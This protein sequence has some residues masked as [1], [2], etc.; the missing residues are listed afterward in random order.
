MTNEDDLDAEGSSPM[1]VAAQQAPPEPPRG[2]GRPRRGASM[3][4][5]AGTAT[6]DPPAQQG[7]P[8]VTVRV[9][10]QPQPQAPKPE[11]PAYAEEPPEDLTTMELLAGS[12]GGVEVTRI[13]PGIGPGWKG[14]KYRGHVVQMGRAGTLANSPRLLDD[15][16]S[17]WGGSR[18][19]FLGS[20]NGKVVE[21]EKILPGAPKD[22]IHED[23]DDDDDDDLPPSAYDPTNLFMPGLGGLGGQGQQGQDP[24]WLWS[25][26]QSRYIYMGRGAPQ[27]PPPPPPGQGAGSF[28]PRL[29]MHPSK[30]AESELAELR[31]KV[32]IE[33]L[34]NELQAL[35]DLIRQQYQNPVA[36]TR[37]PFESIAKMME[38]Q[39][40]QAE[41]D[42]KTRAD[43]ERVR[44]ER[45][46]IE[47][48]TRQDRLDRER[49]EERE[50]YDREHKESREREERIQKEARDREDRRIAEEARRRDEDRK[51]AA[52][53]RTE[54]ARRQ[55]AMLKAMTEKSG[56]GKQITEM[57]AAMGALKSLTEKPEAEKGEYDDAKDLIRTGAEALAEHIIPA[58][59]D[60]LAQWRASKQPVMPVAPPQP[61]RIVRATAMPQQGALPAP[62]VPAQPVVSQRPRSAH[63]EMPLPF[64]PTAAQPQLTPDIIVQAQPTQ[65]QTVEPAQ[66]P[67]P[68]QSQQA[69]IENRIWVS[70]MNVMAE[71]NREGIP[72]AEAVGVFQKWCLE[73]GIPFE[74]VALRLTETDA[75]SVLK[76]L[77]PYVGNPL[78][79]ASFQATIKAAVDM[80]STEAG[81]TWFD[82]VADALEGSKLNLPSM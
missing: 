7:A 39:A 19:K 31:R 37:D 64:R 25:P 33:P 67:T 72:P 75:D 77:S 26:A 41:I 28:D 5:G 30:E 23:E 15:A 2:R 6:V 24:G 20:V 10:P 52:A 71:M 55:D 18:Y 12:K 46:R 8:T 40:K 69:E 62:V 56:I 35:K 49:K 13:G 16:Q 32:E 4:N 60:A 1:D 51:D 43:E 44:L 45:E 27:S 76:E 48:Q 70:V 38:Q 14:S 58:A 11:A 80:L 22:L 3:V 81:S 59:S 50:K 9:T 29:L 36:P 65:A 82:D 17:Q 34:K 21:F 53:A 74:A 73:K 42:R 61:Q 78:V 54:E 47:A 68:E 79:P 66:A 57:V 63:D